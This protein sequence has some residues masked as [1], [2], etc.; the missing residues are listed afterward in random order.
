MKANR[1]FFSSISKSLCMIAFCMMSWATVNAANSV[2]SYTSCN[3]TI[4]APQGNFY[5]ASGNLVSLANRT[6][7]KLQFD[8]VITKIGSYAFHNCEGL[9]S[10]TLP[11]SVTEVGYFAFSNCNTLSKPICNRT[12]F[13]RLPENYRSAYTISAGIKEIA[14][15]AFRNCSNLPSITIPQS[16]T[17]IGESAFAYCTKLTTITIPSSVTLIDEHAFQSCSALKSIYVG[18]KPAQVAA[19]A[20][21][22]I[23]KT[24]CVLYVPMGFKE[25]Y[26]ATITWREFQNIREYTPTGDDVS[27]IEYSGKVTLSDPQ[28]YTNNCVTFAAS[29]SYSRKFTTT[30]WETIVLPVALN[31]A[32]W[33]SK[34][35]IAEIS[36]VNVTLTSAGK[37]SSF[38][39]QQKVLGSGSKTTPNRPYLIRAKTAS[40][41]TA[42]TISKTNC[43][44][45]PA[46]NQTIE[47]SYGN[48]RFQFKG[49]YSSIDAPDMDGLYYT[50]NGSWIVGSSTSS[51]NPTR[52]YLEISDANAAS[53]GND[54]DEDDAPQY[55]AIMKFA[56]GTAYTG[57]TQEYAAI[58]SYSRK[59]AK[60]T[61]GTIV[62]PVAL[63][64]ADW[65]SK[66]EIAEIAGVDITTTSAGELSS[67][68]VQHIVLGPGSTTKPNRPYLIRA[69][70]ASSTT[71]QTISKTNCI[72]YPAE[73]QVIEFI[74]GN[75]TFLFKGTYTKIT[76]PNLTGK[77]FVS[78]GEWVACKSTS[79]MSPMRVYL[80]ITEQSSGS[81][82][83]KARNNETD[84]DEM[85]EEP[86]PEPVK[87]SS[88]LIGLAPGN[89]NINGKRIIVTR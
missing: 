33:S 53:K 55:T 48:Y 45:Y 68:T 75:Y 22:D 50:S 35:E 15:A 69:K 79:S 18:K 61:W 31:H 86:E 28:P 43:V 83:A 32:D 74:S 76:A 3:G 59:F 58:F 70:V 19:S 34:F 30:K 26:G 78:G 49:T 89:Y 64:Y 23:D 17:K 4:D 2:I 27:A 20:F 66:F 67:F 6:T 40:S 52:V 65:S 73:D 25:I 24:Q 14:S 36:G 16:V 10:L 81:A 62:L 56:D 77:Y 71:A 85:Q 29:F 37:L 57:T 47:Y 41:T 87:V 39:V 51:L 13:A 54:E 84:I 63:D 11:N 60:T 9:T 82:K 8:G 1:S 44:V 5:D 46:E 21:N 7:S 38:T 12:I 80:E 72:V 42:K 88:R